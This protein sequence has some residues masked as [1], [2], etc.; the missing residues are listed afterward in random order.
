MLETATLTDSELIASLKYLLVASEERCQMETKSLE[1]AKLQWWAPDAKHLFTAVTIQ[2]ADD[3]KDSATDTVQVLKVDS[4]E[5]VR[6]R[7]ADLLPS[8]P[9]SS[10]KCDDMASMPH[11]NDAT[12][13]HNLRQRYLSHL[14]YTNSGLFCLVVNPYRQLPIY[15]L[16][17]AAL[18]RGRNRVEV[19][20]HLYLIADVAYACMLRDR[21]NQSIIITGESGAGKTENAKKVDKLEIRKFIIGNTVLIIMGLRGLV[22]LPT[23]NKG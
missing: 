14:I 4:N 23:S 9:A 22:V 13:I 10:H 6:L 20:P 1:E 21:E 19:P 17:V 12:I 18:Y 7:R 11:I 15:T 8:N 3:E 5:L 2:E 16:R